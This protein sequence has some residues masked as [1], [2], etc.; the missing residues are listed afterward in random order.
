MKAAITVL[1]VPGGVGDGTDADLL[2]GRAQCAARSGSVSA[3][4]FAARLSR[5]TGACVRPH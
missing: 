3:R 5:L 4:A 2:D 1:D